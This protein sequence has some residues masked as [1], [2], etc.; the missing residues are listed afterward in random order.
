MKLFGWLL[1]LGGGGFFIYAL[2]QRDTM[3][4]KWNSAWG[5]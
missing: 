2:T 1:S 4:Y 3:E 5:G